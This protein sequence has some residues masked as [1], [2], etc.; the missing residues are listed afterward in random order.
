MKS[1]IKR[2]RAFLKRVVLY[3]V[4][5]V[6]VA[7]A[8]YLLFF[9]ADVVTVTAPEVVTEV[10]TQEVNHLDPL[11]E[12]REMELAEKYRKIQNLEARIDVNKTEIARLQ[13]ENEALTAELA[14]FIL[15]TE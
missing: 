15:A 7:T 13:K 8:V 10:V 14:D 2:V 12:Q 9:K 4:L 3:L 1:F 11:Y 5:P 6:V